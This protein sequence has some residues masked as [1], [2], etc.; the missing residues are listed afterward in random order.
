MDTTDRI[1][2]RECMRAADAATELEPLD[3]ARRAFE[4]EYLV[5]LLTLTA[6]NVTHAA[7]QAGRN[8]TEFYRLLSRHGL[9]PASFKR[10]SAVRQ[11]SAP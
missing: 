7:R 6:G 8:R 3:Q 2:P 4:H 1:D 11:R 9:A 10:F 5:H